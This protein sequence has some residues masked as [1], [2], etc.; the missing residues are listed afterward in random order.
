MF[1]NKLGDLYDVLERFGVGL[2]GH[3]TDTIDNLLARH[4]ETEKLFGG[5]IEA[6]VDSP[7][8]V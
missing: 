8:T 4:E 5:G 1:R 7:R 6:R 2:K 3:E